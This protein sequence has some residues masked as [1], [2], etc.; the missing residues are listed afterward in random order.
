M[1]RLLQSIIYNRKLYDRP[2]D[3]WT[4]GRAAEGCPCIY[5][6]SL[7][8][9]C[10]A[11]SQCL[12]A[13]KGDRWVCTRAISLGAACGPGPQPDGTCGCPVPPCR[14]VRSLRA[15][16]GRLTWLVV[17]LALGLVIL[18][19]WGTTHTAWSNPGPLTRQHAVSAQHCAACH[20][21][22]P[23]LSLTAAARTARLQ[24]HDQ[25]CIN[26]HDLGPQ[27]GSPHGVAAAELLALARGQQPAT[28]ARPLGLV[29]ARAVGLP[30]DLA[31][32]TC[33]REHQGAD[34]DLKRMADQQCQVCHQAQFAGFAAGH[35]EFKDYPYERRTRLQFDHVSHFQKHFTDP[36]LATP[37]PT[38]CAQCHEPAPDGQQMLVRGFAQTCAACHTAEI[39]GTSR[40]GAKGL[41]FLRLPDIDIAALEEAGLGVGEWPA[42]CEGGLTPFMRWLLE[43]DEPARAA[44]TT[45]GNLNLSNLR[46]ATPEQ[47][48]AA[49]QLLWSIKGLFADLVT[50]GQPVILRRLG[51]PTTGAASVA[52]R[53][54]QFSPDV[55]LAAQQAWLPNLLVEVAAHRRGEKVARA[56]LILRAT[57]TPA[58]TPVAAAPAADPDD[59]LADLPPATPPAN[60][61]GAAAAAAPGPQPAALKLDEAEARVAAG[62]WYRLD[63]SYTLHYRPGGHE[64]AFLTAWLDGTANQPAPTAQRIFAQLAADD[65]PGACLK[66]HT[67]DRTATGATTVNW[68]TS[69]PQ[70]GVRPFTTFKHAAHFSL[71]G[72]QGCMTCH[73]F[74]VGAD[75]AG[76]F[77]ANRD[78][79]VFHSN[80]TP[81]AKS[82]C[83]TC[84]QPAKSGESCQQCHNYHTGEMKSLRLHAAEIPVA[85]PKPA[86]RGR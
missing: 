68:R 48:A 22:T 74:A 26:C 57:H 15:Q 81:L 12:P 19:L 83:A 25:L 9:E 3:E 50:Q 59:L 31:C 55:M 1:R 38:S 63:E 65:A 44:L 8:G 43:A 39:E 45:L 41:V 21:E 53:T 14:P 11:T 34:F 40:A 85:A 73:T 79:A 62:G 17:S 4:C 70:P 10:R 67:V 60:S 36:R 61:S 7:K 49:A 51:P 64:D 77:G 27:P 58:A 54:G 30:A 46:K 24:Q 23:G 80:F 20:V 82:T 28:G 76:S 47:K 42:Y 29:A 56:P 75:Y 84:H 69:R 71:M 37:G 6:P 35:P 16:R 5:G 78:P 13:K 18:V 32:A 66:C 52:G 86:G 2:Q 33:H 72:D